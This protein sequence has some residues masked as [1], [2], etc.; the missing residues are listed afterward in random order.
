MARTTSGIKSEPV[1]D[2]HYYAQRSRMHNSSSQF[3]TPPTMNGYSA[4]PR[5]Q[6]VT[7]VPSSGTT[8]VAHDD[9]DVTMT[10]GSMAPEQPTQAL[11]EKQ[12]M[13]ISTIQNLEHLGIDATLSSLPKIVVVGNQ[14][15]G[16]SSIVEALC[17][18]SLPRDQGTCTRC[19]FEI[20]T[21]ASEAEWRCTIFLHIKYEHVLGQTGSGSIEWKPLPEQKMIRFADVNIEEQLEQALRLAQI[22]ILNPQMHPMEVLNKN[23]VNHSLALGFSQ[24]LVH[25]K[26]SGPGLPEL[27]LYDLPGVINATERQDEMHFVDFVAELTETYVNDKQAIVLL[28][29]SATTDLENCRAI[30]IIRTKKAHPRCMG[31]L[32]KPDLMASNNTPLERITQLL[33]GKNWKLGDG[34]YVTK[35]S[36][37]GDIDGKITHA[38]ARHKERMFFSEEPWDTEL[39]EFSERFGI[40]K[41]RD[42]LSTKLADHIL[43]EY[44]ISSSSSV[45]TYT[46]VM[47]RLPAIKARVE[48]KLQQINDELGSFPEQSAAPCLEVANE[49]DRVVAA[50]VDNIQGVF[51]HV[52]FRNNYHGLLDKVYGRLKALCPDLSLTTPGYK[53]PQFQIDSDSD[54]AAPSPSPAAKS[55]K[56]NNGRAIATPTQRA[57]ATTR[58]PVKQ[59][60]NAVASM[61]SKKTFTLDE[62]Y[63]EYVSGHRSLPDSLSPQVTDRLSL[64]CMA[65]WPAAFSK[66]S[67]DIKN[68]VSRT[69]ADTIQK[70]LRPR[71]GT[72]FFSEVTGIVESLFVELF[73]K[74]EANISHMVA[75]E[76]Y[77]PLVSD[78]ETHR[79]KRDCHRERLLQARIRKRLDEHFDTL[80]A[81]GAKPVKPEDRRKKLTEKGWMNDNIGPDLYGNIVAEMAKPLAHYEMAAAR[82]MDALKL[83]FEYGLF[84]ALE[85]G[86]KARLQQCLDVANAAYCSSLLAEDAERESRRRAL[87][88]EK[89]KLVKALDEL[90]KLPQML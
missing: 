14:S 38:E 19:P 34:W 12:R 76:M 62:V 42:A 6:R 79:A 31:V 50:I 2:G 59:E 25:L 13:L 52:E 66:A 60:K 39:S 45:F 71:E 86:L 29:Q 73:E 69:L 18:I 84:H 46:N 87:L 85:Q 37:Q 49:I 57:V 83:N 90:H 4:L 43:N 68:C 56:G 72:M 22:A 20:V 65:N 3:E 89:E 8:A 35:N 11:A 82:M 32:T 1:A 27:S 15:Q 47:S 78:E 61:G 28:A 67:K 16:K 81:G 5:N 7:P 64:Q 24:N 36:S 75:C 51:P 33:S 21:T 41:L 10:N 54:D 48:G 55:R 40:C 26:I 17:A 74:Q 44:V 23:D 53:Q 80:Q 77:K 9:N 88:G 58:T 30:A 63:G 70:T